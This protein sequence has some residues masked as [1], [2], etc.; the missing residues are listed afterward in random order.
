VRQ[1][2]SILIYLLFYFMGLNNKTSQHPQVIPVTVLRA[3]R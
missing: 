1:R 2:P 3:V